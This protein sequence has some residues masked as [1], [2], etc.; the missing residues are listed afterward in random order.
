MFTEHVAQFPFSFG[1]TGL[2]HFFDKELR[3]LPFFLCVLAFHRL[4]LTIRIPIL[5]G[6]I[7]FA[8]FVSWFRF[9]FT[10]VSSA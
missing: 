3:L 8:A 4:L 10:V 9:L 2:L 5:S 6:R 1:N 7:F